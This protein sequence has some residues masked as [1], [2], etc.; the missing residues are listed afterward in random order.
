MSC[1]PHA[2]LR[3]SQL[4][5]KD[6]AFQW[7]F[8]TRGFSF[9]D[10]MCFFLLGTILFYYLFGWGFFC[11]VFVLLL[12][13]KDLNAGEEVSETFRFCTKGCGL[14]ERYLQ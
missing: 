2:F 9:P 11:F 5:R 3:R 6:A 13:Y 10:L 1:S 14:V 4:K 8:F 7:F 12:F